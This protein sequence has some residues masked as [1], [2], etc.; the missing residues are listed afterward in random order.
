MRR[1][2]SDV[3]RS[4]LL[5]VAL[6]AAAVPVAGAQVP[7]GLG[8]DGR[9]FTLMGDGTE[10]PR[11][12][13]PAH[14][15]SL[16]LLDLGRFAVLPGGEVAFSGGEHSRALRVGADG[17][18]H[19]LPPLRDVSAMTAAPD[20]TLYAV[21]DDEVIHRLAP[22]ADRWVSAFDPV[23]EIP[24]WRRFDDEVESIAALPGGGFAFTADLGAFRVGD[25]GAV[26]GVAL[27]RGTHPT[28]VAATPGGELVV[29]VL[30][31]DDNERFVVVPPGGA[32]S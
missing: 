22:G 18:V 8:P 27:P 1:R 21:E 15:L 6:V 26:T 28:I 17:R 9:V 3:V 20:G 24:R 31:D 2:G 19:L 11:E 30:D 23:L 10:S 25:D 29:A 32:A 4:L 16:S 5:A 12:G 13:L 7:A 14:R